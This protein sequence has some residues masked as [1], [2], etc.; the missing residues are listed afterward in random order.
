MTY[1]PQFVC[2]VVGEGGGGGEGK[3][4][5]EDCFWDILQTN[6]IDNMHIDSNIKEILY[7]W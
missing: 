4:C 3:E 2:K 5:Y 6:I 1:Y 7:C